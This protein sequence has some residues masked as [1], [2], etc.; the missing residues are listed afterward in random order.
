MVASLSAPGFKAGDYFQIGGE[1]R[2]VWSQA[3][4]NAAWNYINATRPTADT[5][6]DPNGGTTAEA[7]VSTSSLPQVFQNLP[8]PCFTPGQKYT[9]SV[10]L[11]APAGALNVTLLLS[12][13]GNANFGSSVVSLTT[14]WQRFSV[15][16]IAGDSTVPQ[17]GIFTWTSGVTIHAWGAQ[18]QMGPASVIGTTSSDYYPTTSAQQPSIQ[19]LHMVLGDI[20]PDPSTNGLLDIFPRLR[21]SPIYSNTGNRLKF[22]NPQGLFRLDSNVQPVTVDK[23]GHY[24]ISFG[25]EEAF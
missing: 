10:W 20:G 13:G 21:E 24:S 15:T 5:I 19:R 7:I 11:K 16:G 8:L 23:D 25:L 4:E 3:F 2:I 12:T 1:N 9:F 22:A 18:L 17:A 14:S 6:V